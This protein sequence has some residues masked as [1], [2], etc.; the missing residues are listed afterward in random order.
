MAERTIIAPAFTYMVDG[1]PR[2]AWA[3]ETVDLPGD[4][5]V[6]GEALGA[7]LTDAPKAD[8]GH[9]VVQSDPAPLAE[10][11]PTRADATAKRKPGRPRKTTNQ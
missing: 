7:F 2:V 11:A 1:E 6:A 5:I 10:G 4:A 3:G 8:D 9:V